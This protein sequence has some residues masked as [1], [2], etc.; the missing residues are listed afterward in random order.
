[1]TLRLFTMIWSLQGRKQMSYR[2]D[3]WINSVLGFVA[4]LT[5]AY[6]LWA[7]I[8]QATEAESLGGFTFQAMLVYY[9]AAILVGKLVRGQ[10]R[11]LSVARDI[12]EGVLNRYLIYPA[13]YG[14][15][16]YAEHLGSLL[17]AMVQVAVFGGAALIWLEVPTDLRLG[18]GQ[19]ARAALAVALANV[20]AFLMRF[21]IQCLAFWAD[22]VWSLNVMLRLATE[23]LGG[24]MLPLSLFPRAAQD[25]LMWSPFPYLFYFPVQTLLGQVTPDEW[26]RGMGI[27]LLW[28][29]LI[30]AMAMAIWRKGEKTY[31]G[32]GI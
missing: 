14:L 1:M 15:F 20:L 25:L 13:P 18:S 23:L 8:F 30:G 22:N 32:V 11:E 19:V 2:V 24:L 28:C 29:G 5:I 6:C 27:M 12:Y 16:K 9:V 26:Q 21:P 3:F 4:E 7:A 10:E 17:P 31:A